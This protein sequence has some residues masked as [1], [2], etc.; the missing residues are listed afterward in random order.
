[1]YTNCYELLG[2]PSFQGI[3]LA[4][5]ENG[6]NRRVTWIYVLQTESLKGWVNGGEFMFVM[7][8]TKLLPI[9]EEAQA[10]HLSGVVVLKN[11]QNESQLTEE[12]TCYA[13]ANDLPLFEMDY[14]TKLLDVTREI[15]TYILHRQERVDYLNEF[16][17]CL[18]YGDEEHRRKYQEYAIRFNLTEDNPAFM[19]ALKGDAFPQLEQARLQLERYVSDHD[20][21]LLS[22]IINQAVVILVSAPSDQLAKARKVLKSAFLLL[23][24]KYADTLVLGIGESVSSLAEIGQTY[25]KTMKSMKLCTPSHRITDY[26]ELGFSR[27]LLGKESHGQL[28]AYCQFILGPI[29]DYDKVNNASFLS[30]IEAFIL[31]NGNI[32]KTA[33]HLF[34]HRNTCIYRIEKAK[35][36]FL[37]DLENPY[38]RADILNC[39]SIYRFFEDPA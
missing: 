23:E 39:L 18:L 5:G 19:A 17:Y 16:F 24:D 11:P 12:A 29:L 13:D 7:N 33:A 2:L 21:T 25:F 8:L 10:C 6:L 35:E 9:L 20:I 34:I 15:S 27:L 4:A 31:S 30:T 14:Y 26:E 32:N 1:M 28:N 22:L 36:L 37:L 3:H 38:V